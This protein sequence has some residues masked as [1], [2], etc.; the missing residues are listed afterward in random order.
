MADALKK[1]AVVALASAALAKRHAV[2]GR[3]G[4]DAPSV[5]PEELVDA[6]RS[7]FA[8]KL[9]SFRGADGKDGLNGR[10]GVDGVGRD[11][12]DGRDGLNGINGSDGVGVD[13]FEQLS[14]SKAKIVLTDGR[15]FEFD[16]PEGKRGLR[17]SRGERGSDGVSIVG[18]QGEQGAIGPMPRH[19]WEGTKIRFEIAP[20]EWG[21]AVDLQ[22]PKG[23]SG[24]VFVGG[25]SGEA[26]GVGAVGATSSGDVQTVNSLVSLNAYK[27]ITTDEQGNAIY[28]SSANA[29][30]VDQVLGIGQGSG[31][32]VVVQTSG[33][34]TNDG[35]SWIAGKPVYLGVDGDLTQNPNTGVFTLTVGYAQTAKTLFIR[36]GRGVI[37]A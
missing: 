11:G 31:T 21:K 32:S 27:A 16:L 1:A 15:Q 34:I 37:R 33:P 8:D 19:K 25:G 5:T 7:Y 24:Q 36:F 29:A 26:T 30:H 35:W 3:D 4:R 9:E 2:A 20:D 28:A 13:R 23:K 22:G 12:I 10:D 18:E 6:A 17:G 14:E